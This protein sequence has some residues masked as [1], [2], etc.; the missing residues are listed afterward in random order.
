MTKILAD[1]GAE[2][3]HEELLDALW[4]A[5]RLGPTPLARAADVPAA[6][7]ARA[8]EAPP[9]P[10]PHPTP[11]PPPPPP[12]APARP[13]TATDDDTPK[14]SPT[15][16]A[17]SPALPVRTPEPRPTGT[18]QL[19][20]GKALRPLRQRFPDRRRPELDLVRTVAA[21]A[22]TGIPETVTRPARTRWL[23]LAL[24]IDDGVS[25]VLW[26]RLA[27]D[28][29]RLMERAGAFRDVRV[30]GLDTR[31]A[32]P[33]LRTSPYRRGRD[34]S[35]RA[36]CDPSG[37]TLVL[38]ISD[39]VGPA[40]RDGGMRAVLDRWGRCGPVAIVHALPVRLWAGTGIDVRR[41]RIT[42]QRRGG[43]TH[44]WQAADPDLPLD[45]AHFDPVPVPVLTPTPQAV[46]AWARL[47]ASPGGTALL[48]LWEGRTDLART[49]AE[50]PEGDAVLRFREAASAEAYRLAAHVAAVAP[51]TPPVMRLV[52]TA[53]GEPVDAGHLM[54]VF[55]GGLMHEVDT[56]ERLPQHRRFDFTGEARRALLSAVSAGELLRTA[57]AVARDI[58]AAVG[59]SPV[60]PAWVGHPDGTAVVDGTGRSFGWLRE[61]LLVRLGVSGGEAEP[62]PPGWSALTPDDPQR[63]GRFRLLWRSERGWPHIRMYLAQGRDGELVTVRAPVSL[64][65]DDPVAAVELVRTEAECLRRMEGPHAPALVA[66]QADGGEL[67]WIASELIEREGKPAPNL[68][69]VLSAHGG[70]VPRDVFLRI[71]L[72]LSRALVHAHQLG[73][74]HGSVAPRA[75]LQADDGVRLIG[76]MTATVDGADSP[77]RDLLPLTETYLGG[78]EVSPESDV[79]AAGALLL[80]LLA[81]KWEHPRAGLDSRI[82]PGLVVTLRHCLEGDP[83]GRPSARE[84]VDA[85]AYALYASRETEVLDR[86][87]DDIRRL[88]PLARQDLMSHGPILA[89]HLMTFSNH[90]A[91]QGR[92]EEALAQA[93]E[94]VRVWRELAT[95]SPLG[96]AGGLAAALSNLSVR[97]GELGRTQE[98]LDAV[99]EASVVCESRG[100]AS[101][102]AKILNNLSN[103][104][105][106]AGRREDALAVAEEAVQSESGEDLARAYT[107][108]GNR[109]SELGRR[110]EA[111]EAFLA[112]VRIHDGH[113][114]PD[115]A[116]TLNNLAALYAALG[117]RDDA[118]RTLDASAALQ[119]RLEADPRN[120]LPEIRAQSVRI[121]SWIT[122]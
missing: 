63:L 108:L 103:C 102:F 117:R 72:D 18:G 122:G 74:V 113:A 90:L 62:A 47:L 82:D 69:D 78:G 53:L 21:I 80:A 31:A 16:T 107:T 34:L 27:A 118:L 83:A 89:G 121:R 7:P 58:E 101:D 55:L 99:S 36:L 56:S 98:S 61:Q 43:P 17:P 52:Q 42:T 13:I 9:A 39:G 20:L 15:A 111:L 75:V 112:A 49:V 12:K 37:N 73:L 46:G 3:S 93:E 76:W 35:P 38:V 106:A 87:F 120:A 100:S 29:R 33:V 85:F 97:L 71:G 44:T 10:S 84:L 11:T 5:T 116:T 41:A 68:R 66:V 104:L 86:L 54:E 45:L 115:H 2:L 110:E 114:T 77:H 6:P 14:A 105:A 91:N 59:R 79:Y 8:P 50:A 26:Q 22:D 92:H 81:G 65:A 70:V 96:H 48:P 60:F 30:H 1:S 57:D 95:R 119:A 28:V 67:P 24:V 109:L 88:E 94:A 4:L 40:W 19:H 25:M 32:V 51:V 64:Y 23:S